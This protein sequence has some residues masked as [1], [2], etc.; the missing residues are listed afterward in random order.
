M[1][2]APLL[3]A[4]DSCQRSAI[5]SL[6]WERNLLNP[7]AALYRSVEAGL[8]SAEPD[9]GLAAGDHL[10]TLAVN[11]GLDTPQKD[12]LGHAEHLAAL[13]DMTTWLLRTGEP[14]QRVSDLDGWRGS[15]FT[16][17]ARLKRVVLVDHWSE[18][19][20][21]AE[22]H[23]WR[24]LETAIYGLPMTLLVIVLGAQR[25]GRRYGPLSRAWLHP[26]NQGVRFRKRDGSGFDGNWEPIFREKFHGAREDWLNAMTEDGVLADCVLTEE[27]PIPEHAQEIRDL[28][29]RKLDRI[30]MTEA[31]PKPQ[32]SA[33]DDPISPCAYR[34]CCPYW[35][36]PSPELGFLSTRSVPQL[37]LL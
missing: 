30:A 5:L 19:R 7:M 35:R 9:P 25:E 13:A 24:S 8:E 37:P 28:A 18:E 1:N 34:S 3:N 32:L 26:V 16:D 4:D 36:M 33:C 12:L 31:L 21:V 22:S 29:R 15:A 17:G 11:R 14:W 20:L 10:M 6:S 27:I 2:S 23:D